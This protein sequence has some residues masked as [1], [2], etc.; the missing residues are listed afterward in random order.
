MFKYDVY[1]KAYLL[2]LYLII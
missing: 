2:L 1:L